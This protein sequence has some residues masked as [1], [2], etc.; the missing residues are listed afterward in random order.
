MTKYKKKLEIVDVIQW[1]GTDKGIKEIIKFTDGN[2]DISWHISSNQITIFI[3][4][5]NEQLNLSKDDWL[6][7][8]RTGGFKTCQSHMFDIYYEPYSE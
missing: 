4:C 1:N 7:K 2:E 3:K 8:T 6:I 5:I